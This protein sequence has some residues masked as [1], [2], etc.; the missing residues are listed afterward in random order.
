MFR[1]VS[2]T[3]KLTY[4]ILTVYK[5]VCICSPERA[6]QC[7]SSILACLYRSWNLE[8]DKQHLANSESIV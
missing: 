8:D 5:C 7:K 3:L 4:F 2:H 6:G 1:N